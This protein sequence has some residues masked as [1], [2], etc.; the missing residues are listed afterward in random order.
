MG[1]LKIIIF[2]IC[3]AF[4]IS[5]IKNCKSEDGIWKGTVKTIKEYKTDADSIWNSK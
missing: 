4:T 3:A 2:I 1:C 5:C